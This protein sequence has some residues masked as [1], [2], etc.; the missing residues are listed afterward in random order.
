MVIKNT[1]SIKIRLIQAGVIGSILV[2]S[3]IG[4]IAQPRQ[5]GAEPQAIPLAQV[6]QEAQQANEKRGYPEVVARVNG[7]PIYGKDLAMREVVV[8][9]AQDPTVN[10]ANKM[11]IALNQLIKEEVLLQAAQAKGIT[12]SDDAVIADIRSTQ[13]NVEEHGDQQAKESF[14]AYLKYW[15][16]APEQ[17]AKDPMV[18]AEYRRG[19]ILGKMRQQIMMTLQ[20]DQRNDPIAVRTAID[21]FVAQSGARIEM[22]VGK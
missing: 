2:L 22:L 17:L 3:A 6:I 9:H 18:I 4:L 19:N 5:M 12:V 13:Q 1:S 15:G 7:Q 16:D 10:K 11:Q 21:K 8:E 14:A 20:A